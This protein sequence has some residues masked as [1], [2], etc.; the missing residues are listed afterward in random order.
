VDDAGLDEVDDAGLDEVLDEVC[1]RVVTDGVEGFEEH[2]ASR[3]EANTKATAVTT[4]RPAVFMADRAE[5]ACGV[6]AP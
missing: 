4:A 1:G 2:A 5:G 3:G 6:T